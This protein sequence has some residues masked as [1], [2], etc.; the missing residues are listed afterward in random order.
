M[1]DCISRAVPHFHD[2]AE[3]MTEAHGLGQIK[4]GASKTEFAKLSHNLFVVCG[5][6]WLWFCDGAALRHVCAKSP[7]SMA[8]L[9]AIYTASA[10]HEV[11]EDRLVTVQFLASNN[12]NM[13]WEFR[14]KVRTM[15]VHPG[16]LNSNGFYAQ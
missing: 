6:V 10:T 11:D 9:L 3:D 12:A 7:G 13:P 16:K 1:D 8:R 4:T 14:P 2:A 15:K 5:N